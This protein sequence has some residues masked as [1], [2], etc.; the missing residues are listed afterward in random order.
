MNKF[1]I[2]LMCLIV[3]SCQKSVEKVPVPPLTGS[4][5][6]VDAGNV[7]RTLTGAEVG[8]NVDYLMDDSYLPGQTYRTV[9]TSLQNT[10][11]RFLRYPGGEKSDNYLFAKPPYTSASP[12]AAYC[13]FPANQP[14]FYNADLTA[15]SL[16]LDFDEYI[17]VCKQLN[18]T[19]LC[20]VAY[21]A[22][23]S[24]STCGAKPTRAQLL[25]NAKE[26]VRY[27]N[28]TKGYNVKYWMIG[29]ESWNDPDYNGRVTPA[30]Y[31]ADLAQ[32][33]DT[34]R[35]IDPTIRI[36]AN[37]RSNDDWWKVLLQS[38]AA[39]K[40]DYLASSNYLPQG[41]TGYNYFKTFT[42]DLNSEITAAEN[43]LN[44]YATAADKARIGIIL[45]EYNSIEYYNSGWVNENN[46][47]HALCNFQM[48]ADALLHPKLLSACLW[49]TRWITNAE[50]VF[51]IYDAFNASGNLQAT[52]TALGVLGKNLFNGMVATSDSVVTHRVYAT[53]NTT[54]N[55]LNL[56]ILNKD[57]AVKSI[58]VY[59]KNYLSQFSYQKWVF[60][61]T[62]VQDKAPVWAKEGG[63]TT[64]QS[65]MTLSLSGYSV[66]MIEIRSTGGF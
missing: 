37:G 44:T 15:K 54:N 30:V 27:A 20:V 65:G 18:A 52:G 36:V 64:G 39:G 5:I 49:N 28:I 26:W 58:G 42:G 1:V 48:M 41:F 61:G 32:F 47:G 25:T 43:A 7:V 3:L 35:S 57:T 19:P 23:Y 56:F 11:A 40:I 21:D 59:F 6:Q 60:T 14:Q 2:G 24:T 10:G 51:N 31:A 8:I 13:N 22:M 17:T 62:D 9:A 33:A 55:Y 63:V 4:G 46:L 34:M 66:T 45:S 12:S 38:S 50:Q 16:V 29:N 53:K